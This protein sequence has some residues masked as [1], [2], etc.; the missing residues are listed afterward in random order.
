MNIMWVG[1]FILMRSTEQCMCK[2]LWIK[3]WSLVKYKT[4]LKES[5]GTSFCYKSDALAFKVWVPRPSM[6]GNITVDKKS[7]CV[8]SFQ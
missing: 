4:A 6:T 2:R 7:M 5:S 1:V 8:L 3:N